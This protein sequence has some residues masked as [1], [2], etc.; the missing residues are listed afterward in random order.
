MRRQVHM[1]VRRPAHSPGAEVRPGG[2]GAEAES[3]VS[4]VKL[5]CLDFTCGDG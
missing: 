1:E 3:A 5:V 4:K 2:L